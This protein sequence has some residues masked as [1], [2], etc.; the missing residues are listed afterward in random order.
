MK[1]TAEARLYFNPNRWAAY[2]KWKSANCFWR[3]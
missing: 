1:E 3:K 2:K